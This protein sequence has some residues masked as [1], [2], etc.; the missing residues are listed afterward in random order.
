[1][2]LKNHPHHHIKSPKDEGPSQSKLPGAEK[3]GQHRLIRN[4]APP[5]LENGTTLPELMLSWMLRIP[6]EVVDINAKTFEAGSSTLSYLTLI[7]IYIY[8][9]TRGN[10]DTPLRSRLQETTHTR[11]PKCQTSTKLLLISE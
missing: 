9:S 6:N 8:W 3:I 1:V 2:D 5:F 7:Y 10:L 4:P 11:E